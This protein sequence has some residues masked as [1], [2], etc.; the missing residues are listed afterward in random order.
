VYNSIYTT[1]HD[2]LA[3]SPGTQ[4]SY[5]AALT[6]LTSRMAHFAVQ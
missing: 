1:N 6:P 3:G 4:K 2:Q 5:Q